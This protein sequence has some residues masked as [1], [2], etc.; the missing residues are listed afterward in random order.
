M[1]SS[2]AA[3]AAAEDFS[4]P[5]PTSADAPLWVDFRVGASRLNQVNT[6][7]ETAYIKVRC[8]ASSIDVAEIQP[9]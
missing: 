6:A 1:G 2:D 3:A 8:T 7:Q 4:H 5:P 9:L